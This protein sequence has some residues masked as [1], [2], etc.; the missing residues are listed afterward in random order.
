[1]HFEPGIPQ[2]KKLKNRELTSLTLRITDQN[3]DVITDGL[4]VTVSLHIHDRKI[5]SPLKMEYKN[6]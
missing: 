1:M 4:Q 2:Y 6:D 5:L 3:I